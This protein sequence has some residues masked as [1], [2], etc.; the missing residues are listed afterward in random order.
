M[1]T[2]ADDTLLLHGVKKFW[3]HYWPAQANINYLDVSRCVGRALFWTQDPVLNPEGCCS[4][5]RGMF[6]SLRVQLT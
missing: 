1:L 4:E 5:S 6:F 2:Y 3:V